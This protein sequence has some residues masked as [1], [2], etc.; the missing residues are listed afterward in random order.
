M[1][2]CRWL[3]L[4]AILIVCTSAHALITSPLPMKDILENSTYIVLAK[5]SRFEPD[6]KR[7]ILTITDDLK[8][9]AAFRQIP[10]VLEGDIEGKALNHPAQLMKR[11]AA[12]LP[13]VV[14][15]MKKEN[16]Y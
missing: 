12:D 1:K 7:M 6:K 14:F 4:V 13:V 9:K 3:A 8:D 11:L 15:I 2:P 10:I 5:V 16:R